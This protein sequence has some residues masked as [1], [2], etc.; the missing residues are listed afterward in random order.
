LAVVKI[1][2]KN[3]K[4]VAAYALAAIKLD[5]ALPSGTKALFKLNFTSCIEQL[6]KCKW[7]YQEVSVPLVQNG[8]LALAALPA[9]KI[10]PNDVYPVQF[11][12]GTG[13]T[14]ATRRVNWYVT[15]KVTVTAPGYETLSLVGNSLSYADFGWDGSINGG[16][17]DCGDSGGGGGGG[18]TIGGGISLDTSLGAYKW[19]LDDPTSY[20]EAYPS[21][22]KCGPPPY[23]TQTAT[24][25]QTQVAS[26]VVVTTTTG[27]VVVITQSTADTKTT[28]TQTFTRSTVA[29]GTPPGGSYSLDDKGGKECKGYL[30]HD[31]ENDVIQNT[32]GH[33][34]ID[35]GEGQG[36]PGGM[37]LQPGE[38][39][40]IDLLPLGTA[41]PLSW[42]RLQ[43]TSSS[44][45][46]VNPATYILI[47]LGLAISLALAYPYLFKKLK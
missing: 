14:T 34:W 11:A 24:Q 38:R 37:R 22:P 41:V 3:V 12:P 21:N 44:V 5:Q 42:Q 8:T 40:A 27:T 23:P 31:Y 16:C 39:V 45:Y 47:G 4:D 30:C 36:L 33:E 13:S 20:C 32:G 25:T 9:F 2:G 15:G 43:L 18:G 17:T 29:G 28:V 35:V 6:N 7:Q 46:L 19:F 10:L 1:H 26:T